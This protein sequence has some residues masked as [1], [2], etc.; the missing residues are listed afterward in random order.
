MKAAA[1]ARISY[2]KATANW[3]ALL[4]PLLTGATVAVGLDVFTARAFAETYVIKLGTDKGQLQFQ[5][6]TLTIK[7]GDTIVWQVNKFAPHNVVFDPIQNPTRDSGLA[8]SLS[9]PKL[10]VTAG[11]TVQS[12]FPADAPAGTYHFS[13]TPQAGLGMTGTIIVAP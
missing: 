1:S 5:P 10:M 7:P 12:V 8:S 3:K 9:H 6:K 2:T 13:S 4:F 11:Q